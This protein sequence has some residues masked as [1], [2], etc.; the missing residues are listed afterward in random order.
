MSRPR[1]E[2]LVSV[3]Q[4][5][6]APPPSAF[7][8]ATMLRTIGFSLLVNGVCPYLLYT[9]LE[10]HFPEGAF[11]PLLYATVFP[12]TGLAVG[13]VRNRT[14]DMI[15]AIVLFSMAVN[16]AAI[17]LTPNLKWALVARSLNGLF[18]ATAMLLS[19]LIGR[20][21]FYYVARQFVSANPVRL[22]GFDAANEADGRRTFVVVTLVWAF[23]IYLLCA[24]NAALALTV[25][26]A[27]YLLASQITN[28]AFNVALSLWTIRFTTGRLTRLATK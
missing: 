28:I 13:I 26:P 4:P 10:P 25:Q 9:A 11:Q 6:T 12:L 16:I 17:F 3:E 23:G 18:I 8:R 5:P 2:S 1:G 14:V 19:A 15:A 20:P 27:N 21:V 22:Q 24:V 7:S